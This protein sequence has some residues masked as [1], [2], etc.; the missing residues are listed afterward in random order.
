[1]PVSNTLAQLV[2]TLYAQGLMALRA[3][4]VMP[5]LVMNDFGDEVKK[6]GDVIQVP[7]PSAI[8]T[9]AVVPAAYAPD[10]GNLA[11]TT[12]PVAMNQWYEAAFAI[13]EQELART[14]DGVVP[15]QLTAAIKALAEQVNASIFALFP[16]VSSVVG[17]A[18][19]TP[20]GNDITAATNARR[21]LTKALAPISDRRIVLGPDAYASA[22]ALPQ[23]YG[24]QFS[25]DT[26]MIRKGMIGEKF[27]FDWHEDQQVPTDTLGTITTGLAAQA[28][29][30]GPTSAQT[31]LLS[32]INA[33]TAASTGACALNAGNLVQFSGD[34]QVYS[35]VANAVQPAHGA[36]VALTITPAKV[37]PLNGGEAITLV[38]TSSATVNLAF[39]PWAFAFASRPLIN[40][41]LGRDID[42]EMME[43]DPVSGLSL[44]LTIRNEYRRTRFAFDL[45]WGTAPV[46]PQLAT[47]IQG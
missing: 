28:A 1:M 4:C 40:E 17:T 25:G 26:N 43:P 3:N 10:P 45:L 32:T 30:A 42:M 19:T 27:G 18:G 38:N 31:P 7:L 33:T 24:A 23:F 35:L 36:T 16:Y 44:R 6:K 21:A 11:P 20:F 15:M 22:L 41:E 5:R 2:P 14:I 12:A 9:V 37:V 46:R 39:H 47:R 29:P 8:Q 34:S 13:S